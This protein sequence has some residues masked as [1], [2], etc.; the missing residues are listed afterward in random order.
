MVVDV[1][2]TTRESLI[3]SVGQRYIICAYDGRYAC[4][5]GL[6]GRIS[7][8]SERKNAVSRMEVVMTSAN[9]V[10]GECHGYNFW[11]VCCQCQASPR[12]LENRLKAGGGGANE[13]I[14]ASRFSVRVY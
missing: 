5:T 13:T 8:V 2:G 14:L 3:R 4:S 12:R 7:C 1:V 6:D 11:E 10:F 9:A